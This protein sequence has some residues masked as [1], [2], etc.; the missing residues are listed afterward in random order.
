MWRD[1]TFCSANGRQYSTEKFRDWGLVTRAPRR[2]FRVR[3]PLL[4]GRPNCKRT[5]RN[6][7]APPPVFSEVF[8]LKGFKSCVLEVR[9]LNELW[10]CFFVSADS[11]GLSIPARSRDA[12]EPREKVEFDAESTE[13]R[14]FGRRQDEG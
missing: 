14:E 1:G 2:E 8:I 10:E 9:I 6:G 11:K 7:T 12:S 3:D 4:Q 5:A 13:G